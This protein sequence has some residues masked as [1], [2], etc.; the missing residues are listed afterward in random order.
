MEDNCSENDN[1]EQNFED[2]HSGLDWGNFDTIGV[3]LTFNIDLPVSVNAE[4]VRHKVLSKKYKD[5]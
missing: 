1:I 4:K 3:R 5:P 2:S